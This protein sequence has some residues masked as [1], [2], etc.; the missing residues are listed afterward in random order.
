MTATMSKKCKSF[1]VHLIC[2]H[3]SILISVWQFYE[4]FTEYMLCSHF[5]ILIFVWQFYEF[6]IEYMLKLQ[7]CQLLYKIS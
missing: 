6:F 2:S 3:F 1:L 5:S 4:F 7:A